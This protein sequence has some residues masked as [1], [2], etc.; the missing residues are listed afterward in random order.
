VISHLVV[1]GLEAVV[2]GG[3]GHRRVHTMNAGRWAEACIVTATARE[4]LAATVLPR[5]NAFLAG[6]GVRRSPPTTGITQSS[7]GLDC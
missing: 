5:I 7:P 6:R 2:H 3:S 4:V 1:D